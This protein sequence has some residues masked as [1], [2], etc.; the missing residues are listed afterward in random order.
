MNADTL[1]RDQHLSADQRLPRVSR[2]LFQ[3]SPQEQYIHHGDLNVECFSC[4]EMQ[5]IEV[6][7]QRSSMARPQFFACFAKEK[8]EYGTALD[9][10]CALPSLLTK[11]GRTVR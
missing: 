2:R 8:I 4:K 1:E 7:M 10:L 5:T 6:L 11:T 9:Q 3:S